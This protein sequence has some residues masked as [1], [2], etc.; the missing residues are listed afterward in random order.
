MGHGL[1]KDV[2]RSATKVV[3]VVDVVGVAAAAP[4]AVATAAVAETSAAEIAAGWTVGEENTG[5]RLETWDG[6]SGHPY[7]WEERA[8]G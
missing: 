6:D 7:V 8:M 4:A 3:V 5:A 2:C 1:A